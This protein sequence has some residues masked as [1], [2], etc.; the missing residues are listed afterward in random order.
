MDNKRL[1]NMKAVEE[2][3]LKK[4]VYGGY[5]IEIHMMSGGV[6]SIPGSEIETIQIVYDRLK[7]NFELGNIVELVGYA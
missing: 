4:E 5:S 6:I 1:I 7:E 3:W 2:I